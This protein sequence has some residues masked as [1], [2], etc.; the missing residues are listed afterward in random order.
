MTT[1]S[2]FSRPRQSALHGFTL[3]EVLA[4]VVIIGIA[5]AAIL[6]QIG[7]RD[8]MRTASAARALMA[9]LAYVQSRAVSTQRKHYVRFD[10][11]NNRY[12]VLDQFS[13]SERVITH[14]VDKNEFRVQFGSTR[15]DDL[16]L[17]GLNSVSFGTGK[18]VLVFDELGTPMACDVAG[19]VATPLTAAGTIELKARSYSM[20]VSVEP[21]SGELNVN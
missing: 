4:V 15:S 14:P 8:D 5:A 12:E 17:V 3:V 19:G 18:T 20:T 16:K 6:P 13:P 11:I 1:A 21:L 7:N 10:V 9:D 2:T